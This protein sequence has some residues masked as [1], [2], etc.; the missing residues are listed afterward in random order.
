MGFLIADSH[1]Q[2]LY[3]TLSKNQ[4]HKGITGAKTVQ[5]FL[6]V[7]SQHIASL[8]LVKKNFQI[9]AQLYSGTDIGV[10]H[11]TVSTLSYLDMS[12]KL[13]LYI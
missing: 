11:V 10:K 1:F 8:Y 6:C 4:T 3:S 2:N 9:F 7:Q 12:D 13:H 5:T